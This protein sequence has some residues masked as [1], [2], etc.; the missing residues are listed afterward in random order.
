MH[1][2]LCAYD[3]TFLLVISMLAILHCLAWSDYPPDVDPINF[4]VALHNFAPAFDSPHPPGY[5]LLV[6]S[7]RLAALIVGENHAYQIVNL[8]MLLGSG[9]TLY[10]L[11]RHFNATAIGFASAVLLITHPLV[12]AA[13]AIPE[14]YISD[15][16]FGI[17]ILTFVMVQKGSNQRLLGGVFVLFFL[18]GMIR[19]VSGAML[20]PLAMM[21]CYL[22][23]RSKSLPLILAVVATIAVIMA[24]GI[25]VYLSGGLDIYRS[26]SLRVMGSAFRESSILGGAPLSAHLKMLTHLIGWLLLLALPMVLSI[27]IVALKGTGNSNL[28]RHTSALM[29]GGAWILP[30]LAFYSVI[31]YLKPTYQLI[32]L[33]CLLIP[34]AWVLYGKAHIFSKLSANLILFGLVIAQLAIF[35]LPIPHIPQAIHRQTEAY[36]IQQDHAWEQLIRELDNLPKKHTL[37]IWATH[38]SLTVYAV[39]LLDRETPIAVANQNRTRIN[40]LDPKTMHWLPASNA[41]TMIDEKYDGVVVIDELAGK[42]VVKYIPLANRQH[43]KTE[44]LLKPIL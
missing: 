13:T 17:A 30:P 37:L 32:Y 21:G 43:R 36:I 2:R 24:Y 11:F 39:R 31:Y 19:P 16:F 33:P 3:L 9:G 34:I 8:V 35:F 18:L 28:G 7:A 22:T 10:W 25:T 42:A 44:Y 23:T 27:L 5:P 38:P 12:W 29:I 41:D 40:Y 6:F 15:V 14:C 26:A 1:K 20:L 4:T